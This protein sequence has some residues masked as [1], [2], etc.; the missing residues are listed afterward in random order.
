MSMIKNCFFVLFS[1]ARNEIL[2]H[3]FNKR[4]ESFALCYSQS[5][6]WIHDQHFVD[7]KNEGRKPDKESRVRIL[8]SL[9]RNLDKYYVH[10]FHLGSQLSIFCC[11]DRQR[12]QLQFFSSRKFFQIFFPSKVFFPD[13]I[14]TKLIYSS[15]ISND[16]EVCMQA[17]VKAYQDPKAKTKKR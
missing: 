4:L 9:L 5:L 11:S 8:E 14:D 6:Q 17:T 2:G 7:G 13:L 12:R 16:A 1:I 10:E 15:I 3:R